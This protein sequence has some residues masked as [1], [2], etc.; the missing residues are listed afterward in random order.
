MNHER[1]RYSVDPAVDLIVDLNEAQTGRLMVGVAVN[2]DAGLIGQILI[3]EQNF[4]WQRLPHRHVPTVYPPAAM[5]LFS[6]AARLPAS[7]LA[8]KT[9]L[10]VADLATCWLLLSLARRRGLPP[11]RVVWYAWNPLVA[12]EVAGMGHVDALGVTAV[13]ATVC[14]VTMRPR[15]LAGAATTAAAAVLAKLIPLLALPAFARQSGRPA[16]FLLLSATLVLV[17]CAPLLVATGGVPPGLVTFLRSC[18]GGSS[19][20]SASWLA[21]ATVTSASRAARSRGKPAS[22]PAS[23]RQSINRNT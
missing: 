20:R 19:P 6:I 17:A 18:A 22:T 13:A 10:V 2:S 12:L 3:D 15:R 14:L 8:L 16:L 9:L 1:P 4:D 5:A 23:A 21:P 7:L 11:A